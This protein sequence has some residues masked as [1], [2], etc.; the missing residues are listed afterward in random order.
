VLLYCYRLCLHRCG[1]SAGELILLGFLVAGN[2]GHGFGVC[3][4]EQ[5][6]SGGEPRRRGAPCVQGR[7]AGPD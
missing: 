2:C 6:R 3:V 5:E 4:S 1:I 7:A